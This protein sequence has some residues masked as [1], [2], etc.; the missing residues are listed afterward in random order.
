MS[1]S[2]EATEAWLI[3]LDTVTQTKSPEF[4]VYTPGYG[5]P[6]V[7]TGKELTDTYS[8]MWAFAVL[9]YQTLTL[10]HPLIGDMAD[11]GEPGTG[12]EGVQRRIVR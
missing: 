2:V 10:N 9:C 1:E 3:D 11:D 12:R 5:A 6:E 7:V 8:D 4:S